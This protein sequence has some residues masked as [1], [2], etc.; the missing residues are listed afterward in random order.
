MHSTYER[1]G[2]EYLLYQLNRVLWV[3]IGDKDRDNKELLLNKVIVMAI[4]QP[5]LNKTEKEKM[6][7]M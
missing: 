4:G 7:R 5:Q 3:N 1:R 6:S 2:S